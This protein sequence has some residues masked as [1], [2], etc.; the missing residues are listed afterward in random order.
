MDILDQHERIVAILRQARRAEQEVTP[1]SMEENLR[2]LV[3]LAAPEV[4]ASELL[5]RRV[6][7][8]RIIYRGRGSWQSPHPVRKASYRR[9]P[10]GAETRWERKP[11]GEVFT[12][13]EQQVLRLL[14][15]ADIQQLPEDALLREEAR[16]VMR[17]LLERLPEPQ[18]EALLLQVRHGLSIREIAQVIGQSEAQTYD[19][20]HQAR[21]AFFP[22]G[23]IR[24][25]A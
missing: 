12:P 8:L 16:Q 13:R 18:R 19:L 7:A 15:T 24:F 3:R 10:V 5:R 22:P 23:W 2:W 11:C 1:E 4:P 25:D 6:Q 17:Q 9:P 20:L 14:L 21:E